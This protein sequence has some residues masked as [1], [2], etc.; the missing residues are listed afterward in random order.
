MLRAAMGN[1]DTVCGQALGQEC[2]GPTYRVYLSAPSRP[3]GRRKRIL[4]NRKYVRLPNTAR[5]RSGEALP[6]AASITPALRTN[7]AFL[8]YG[9]QKADRAY[10]PT[11]SVL[12]RAVTRNRGAVSTPQLRNGALGTR[13]NRGARKGWGIQPQPRRQQGSQRIEPR[14]SGSAPRLLA[15]AEIRRRVAA[16]CP[17]RPC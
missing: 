8:K 14:A 10:M 9:K 4:R 11:S 5:I 2:H 15:S 17:E 1:F 13:V 7:A 16:S 12:R 6:R 3:T